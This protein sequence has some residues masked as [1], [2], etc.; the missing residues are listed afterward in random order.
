LVH[1]EVKTAFSA[2][3]E[4]IDDELP[5]EAFKLHRQGMTSYQIARRLLVSIPEVDA[6]LDRVLPKVDS[7][8]RSRSICS[9]VADLDTIVATH[10]ARLG[11]R[12]RRR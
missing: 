3:V 6:A 7:G 8:Y 5:E 9:A 11:T 10:M 2:P 12:I 1:P 4:L